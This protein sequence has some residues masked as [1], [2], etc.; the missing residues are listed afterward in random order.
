MRSSTTLIKP[1]SPTRLEQNRWTDNSAPWLQLREAS[2]AILLVGPSGVSCFPLFAPAWFDRQ[3]LQLRDRGR[4]IEQPRHDASDADPLRTAC[5]VSTSAPSRFRELS[6]VAA[7]AFSSWIRMRIPTGAIPHSLAGFACPSCRRRALYRVSAEVDEPSAPP[8]RVLLTVDPPTSRQHGSPTP[9]RSQTTRGSKHGEFRVSSGH[10]G[11]VGV[12]RHA[13]GI[14]H[15]RRPAE[16]DQRAVVSPSR[17]QRCGRALV[18][19]GRAVVLTASHTSQA[20]QVARGLRASGGRRAERHQLAGR[21]RAAVITVVLS[22]P[23]SA[24]RPWLSSTASHDG[25]PA[26][27]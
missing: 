23:R 2:V 8:S 21:P 1:A 20:R 13:S 9:R 7:A 14:S 17:S 25:H 19:N 6:A 26:L 24:R 3:A 10:E 16:N 12:A 11:V 27:S 15:T 18:L 5:M 22:V 4:R